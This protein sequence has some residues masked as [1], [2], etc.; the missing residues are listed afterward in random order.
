MKPEQGK[1]TSRVLHCNLLLSCDYLPLEVE[2]RRE[3]KPK[4]TVNEQRPSDGNESNPEEGEDEDYYYYL[5]AVQHQQPVEEKGESDNLYL[6][7]VQ[8]N[9]PERGRR[10][11]NLE[12]TS[13]DE[14]AAQTGNDG[15]PQQEGDAMNEEQPVGQPDD[16]AD[17]HAVPGECNSEGEQVDRWPRRKRRPPK[18]F[19]YDYLGTP[20]CYN[21]RNPN[22][23]SFHSTP[24]EMQNFTSWTY[25]V[26]QYQ[27]V[28]LYAY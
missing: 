6:P 4:K 12:I 11:V 19:T 26:S 28:Y 23:I 7:V 18:T 14:T 5:P 25:P 16:E 8:P 27:P 3:S 15:L 17:A 21:I 10:E 9:E 13:V 20:E 22:T 2:L 1:G 24:Y